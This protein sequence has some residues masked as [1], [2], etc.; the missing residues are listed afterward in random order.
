MI[1]QGGAIPV[2]IFIQRNALLSAIQ[3]VQKAVTSKTTIPV[4]SGIKLSVD[5]NGLRMTAT[6]LE[7]GIE[8]FVPAYMDDEEIVKV[9]E[10]GSIVLPA[11]YFSEII[12]KLPYQQIE[13]EVKE[14]YLTTICGGTSEFNLLGLDAEEFPR[15]PQVMGDRIFSISSDVFKEMIRQ[16]VFATSTE[17]IRPILTGVVLSLK[18]GLLRLVATDSHRLAQRE[19]TVEAPADLTLS[20]VIIPGKSLNELG[21]LLPDDDQLVDIVVANNQILVKMENTQFY[22]RLIDGQYPD[23]SR[24]FPTTFKTSILVNTKELYN[25]IERASL[26]ARE[27]NNNIVRFMITPEQIKITSTS[28]DVGKV[29]ETF[30]PK[31]VKGEELLLA[32]NAKYIMDALRVFD[33]EEILVEFT[34]SMSPFILK[35]PGETKIMQLVLPIRMN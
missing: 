24:L 10:E 26:I 16:T 35:I 33:A 3:H 25:A 1:L 32:F 20:N 18:D 29:T 23:T 30:I 34:G 6:D 8:T 13:L 9:E 21:R 22:S 2:K 7:I 11:R 14:N 17:E 27:N 5:R 28:A 4:L 19:E 12:R 31:E 15:L